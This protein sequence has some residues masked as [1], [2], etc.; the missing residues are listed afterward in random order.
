MSAV[1]TLTA[2]TQR[3]AAALAL[4]GPAR[5]LLAD[6]VV[7]PTVVAL[8]TVARNAFGSDM[9]PFKD[10]PYT[11][12]VRADVEPTPAGAA[13]NFRLGPVGFWVMGQYGARPHPIPARHP[14][15]RLKSS[16]HP[17]PVRAP[18]NHPGTRGKRAI[19]GAWKAVRRAQTDL[20]PP[21]VD[22]IVLGAW[23]G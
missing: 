23:N 3:L 8:Q 22:R 5:R 10:R 7:D 11:A 18:I 19:D 9:R 21:A 4:D 14:G 12:T 17:H 13:I 6:A 2:K 16:S 20:V 15:G 1:I